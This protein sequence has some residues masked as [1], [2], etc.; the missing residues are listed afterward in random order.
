MTM[1]LNGGK[2]IPVRMA[3]INGDILYGNITI[4]GTCNRIM[5][6]LNSKN[7]SFIT[8]ADAFGPGGVAVINRN[9]IIYIEP[10]DT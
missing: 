2:I 1:N 10:Q 6:Y 9:H 8:I 5:D 3:L 4:H 7:D